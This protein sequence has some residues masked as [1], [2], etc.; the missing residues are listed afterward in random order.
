MAR[1]R[2]LWRYE[3]YDTGREFKSADDPAKIWEGEPPKS[4]QYSSRSL[5]SP[6]LQAARCGLVT[7]SAGQPHVE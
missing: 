7:D 1:C 4:N 6:T 2:K 5:V 3:C